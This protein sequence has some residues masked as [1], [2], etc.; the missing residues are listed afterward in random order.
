MLHKI[1]IVTISL[2]YFIIMKHVYM[3]T[4]VNVQENIKLHTLQCIHQKFVNPKD[5]GIK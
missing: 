2:S 5:N 3:N 4:D 1:K